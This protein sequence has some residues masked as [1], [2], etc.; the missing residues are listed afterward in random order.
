TYSRNAEINTSTSNCAESSCTQ[1][2]SEKRNK[3]VPGFDTFWATGEGNVFGYAEEDGVHFSVS[4]AKIL[5]ENYEK[6][7]SLE[8]FADVDADAY[9][10][11]VLSGDEADYIANQVYLMNATQ[12]LLEDAAGTQDSTIARYWRTRNGTAD[13]H[14]SFSIAYNIVNAAQMAGAEA[15]YSLVW[16]M[17]HGSNEGS[18]TGTFIEWVEAICPC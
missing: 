6:Y 18:T 7:Q 15:D 17:T 9:I 3:D 2:L 13:E 11:S 8:G 14:T 12:I 10:E 1:A 16:A 5:E 4:V